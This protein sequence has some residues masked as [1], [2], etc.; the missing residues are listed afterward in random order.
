MIKTA[1]RQMID[2]LTKRLE[3]LETKVFGKTEQAQPEPKAEP[4][5]NGVFSFNDR[6]C[7]CIN[8]EQILY[9]SYRFQ[10]Y[11]IGGS[12]YFKPQPHRL[13][14]V[15]EYTVGNWY[16]C[17]DED[18]NAPIAYSMYLGDG[19]FVAWNNDQDYPIVIHT[20]SAFGVQLLEVQPVNQ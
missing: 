3:A 12:R 18:L 15:K 10:N 16:A 11:C 8:G 4:M 9:Y 6:E 19:E 17:D 7:Y 5:Y 13:V 1:E 2:Q 14:P 20:E